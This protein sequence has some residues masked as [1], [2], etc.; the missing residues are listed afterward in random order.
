MIPSHEGHV[1][2]VTDVFGTFDQLLCEPA[3]VFNVVRS[4]KPDKDIQK[5]KFKF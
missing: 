2:V 4:K 1:A 5:I 3:C